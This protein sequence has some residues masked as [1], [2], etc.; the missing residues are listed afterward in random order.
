MLLA[1]AQSREC[2]VLHDG[3]GIFEAKFKRA[4]QQIINNPSRR[5]DDAAARVS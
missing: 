4:R 5:V 3:I 2:D 1:V